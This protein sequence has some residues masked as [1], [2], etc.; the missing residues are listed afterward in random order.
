MAV[1]DEERAG[2]IRQCLRGHSRGMTITG[3]ASRLKM[4]RNIA[5]KYLD[6]LVI[7]GQVEMQEFGATKVYSL[8]QRIPVSA[9]LEF[10]SDFIVVTDADQRILQVNEPVARLLGIP[11]ETLVDNPVGEIDNPF[12]RSLP[13]PGPA[14]EGDPAR[15]KIAETYC[16]INGKTCHFRVRLVP[17]VFENGTTGATYF[18]E[19]ITG[20][21][22]AEARIAT[23]VKNLEFLARN[24]ARFADMGDDENIYQFI[25]DCLAEIEPKAFVNVMSINPETKTTVLRAIAGNPEISQ[26]LL[27]YFGA[28]FQGEI[29]MGETPEAW[30]WL[31]TGALIDGMKTTRMKSLYEQTYHVLPEQVCNE[32][33]DQLKQ[34]AAYAMGCTCRSGLYGNIMIRF[35]ENDDLT[36][37]DTIVAFVRQAGVALQR[38]HLR[39]KLRMAE[40]KIRALEGGPPPAGREHPP[41]ASRAG[42]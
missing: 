24:S 42:M 11:P 35:R 17:T 26:I 22:E 19:D 29:P 40:E 9:M 23:Y 30:E 13:V 2:R 20:K 28:F 10:S 21:K 8:S 6:M 34:N 5:A 7:A 12:F 16:T 41:E 33:E 1:L 15:E 32:I 4:N 3:V 14:R 39:E 38:R 31:S 27:N 18:L 37:R 36:N 25:A